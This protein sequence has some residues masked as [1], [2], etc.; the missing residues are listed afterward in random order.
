M[1]L[2]PLGDTRFSF[3]G[4]GRGLFIPENSLT[5]ENTEFALALLSDMDSNSFWAQVDLMMAARA[6]WGDNWTQVIDESKFSRAY[7]DQR[8]QTGECFPTSES[9]R[10]DLTP[11]HYRHVSKDYLND[12]ERAMLLDWTVR[13]GW[14]TTYLAQVVRDY[15]ADRDKLP[16]VFRLDVGQFI[17]DVRTLFNW[18]RNRDAPA[19]V[20]EPV[21]GQ[22]EPMEDRLDE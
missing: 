18:A 12:E 15:K 14:S 17:R 3:T 20:L 6:K 11:S 1:K 21:L 22:L 2:V 4:N 9:R 16:P 10:W 13:H 7:V 8:I 19:D 5:L